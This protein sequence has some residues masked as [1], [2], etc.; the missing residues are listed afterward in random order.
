MRRLRLESLKP[1]PQCWPV[2]RCGRIPPDHPRYTQPVRHA[3]CPRT[4][5]AVRLTDWYQYG[6]SCPAA[7]QLRAGVSFTRQSL[8]SRM[9][10]SDISAP[11]RFIRSC[12]NKTIRLSVQLLLEVVEA[13]SSTLE[14]GRNIERY[15]SELY[16]RI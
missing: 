4:H 14:I 13:G 9:V 3:P 7:W 1:G 6:T 15:V 10:S 2:V 16:A 11:I 12:D 5:G 8:F